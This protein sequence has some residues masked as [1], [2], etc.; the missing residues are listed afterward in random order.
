[1]SNTIKNQTRKIVHYSILH[2][3]FEYS[4]SFVMTLTTDNEERQACEE[5][6]DLYGSCE[7]DKH[8]ITT[9]LLQNGTATTFEATIYDVRVEDLDTI[10]VFVRGGVIQDIENIPQSVCIRVQDYDV[11]SITDEITLSCTKPDQEGQIYVESI[12]TS[13][14]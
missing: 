2:H 14:D 9:N 13:N 4:D 5:I 7:E 8:I 11:D 3:D 12:W 6:A 10:T 1:M